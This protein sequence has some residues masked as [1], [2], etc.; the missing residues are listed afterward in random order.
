MRKKEREIEWAWDRD[1]RSEFFR[2]ANRQVN[3]WFFFLPEIIFKH[4]FRFCEKL[5]FV[6]LLTSCCQIIWVFIC[7][8]NSVLWYLKCLNSCLLCDTGLLIRG[9]TLLTSVYILYI[10]ETS[11]GEVWLVYMP[12]GST[13][14][15]V[16]LWFK[17]KL[18]KNSLG[19]RE[20]RK[21]AWLLIAQHT[22]H[23]CLHRSWIGISYLLN[24]TF[25]PGQMTSHWAA[26]S[27][28]PFTSSTE[29]IC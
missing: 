28:S 7:I 5:I 21:A 19:C 4:I 22:K 23:A 16:M 9:R 11:A 20:K 1:R 29:Q 12:A 3:K 6:S 24:K 18:S 2:W 15:E 27:A 25:S 14:S 17:E 8:E 26:A 13:W 10:P